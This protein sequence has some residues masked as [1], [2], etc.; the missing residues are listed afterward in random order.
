SV[1]TCP[2]SSRRGGATR[3]GGGVLG[4]AI[5]PP[6]RCRVASAP[7]L[8]EGSPLHFPLLVE[9]GWREAT[10]WWG[11]EARNHPSA[12]R[13]RRLCPSFTGGECFCTFPS[14]SRRGG[15]KCRGGEVLGSA[16]TPRRRDRVASAPPSQEGSA[17]PFPSSSRRGG[18]KRRGGEVSGP[19]TTPR[20]RDRVASA[21]PSQEGSDLPFPS[22]SR[23]GGAK[24]RGGEV[25]GSATTPRRRGR[26]AS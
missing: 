6:R 10:G 21:P 13:P 3:R 23:R 16:T 17:L 12:P 5:P 14:S 20:R 2:A 25:S 11:F 8:Q 9:E 24:C 26:A 1:L 15:A 22:S 18:A 7:S 19:A 4:P